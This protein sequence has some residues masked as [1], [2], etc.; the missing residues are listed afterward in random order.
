MYCREET[1][2]RVL[3]LKILFVDLHV[4]FDWKLLV[5]KVVD[6]KLSVNLQKSL[7]AP[8]HSLL[9]TLENYRDFSCVC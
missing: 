4:H 6:S 9:G 7:Q 8:Q 1:G 5:M 2:S 3:K